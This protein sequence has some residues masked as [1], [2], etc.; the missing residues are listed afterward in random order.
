MSEKVKVIF[1]KLIV[2]CGIFDKSACEHIDVM[3]GVSLHKSF[4][5]G[6]SILDIIAST[7]GCA[8]MPIITAH[9]IINKTIA[10][11]RVLLKISPFED[12]HKYKIYQRHSFVKKGT[13]K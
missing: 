12:F 13:D 6:K 10:A 9:N 5:L 3:L 1:D 8:A 7:M 11:L 2:A 4:T